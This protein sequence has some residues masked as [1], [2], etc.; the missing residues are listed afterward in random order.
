M[1]LIF[2]LLKKI[3]IIRQISFDLLK[4]KFVFAIIKNMNY[5]GK[6]AYI[7]LIS[8]LAIFFL[9]S[10]GS[11]YLYL[12]I[13]NNLGLE[14]YK[15]KIE[16]CQTGNFYY[17]SLINN[18]SQTNNS[19]TPLFSSAVEAII[20][21]TQTLCETQAL[22]MKCSG[23]TTTNAGLTVAVESSQD[24]WKFSDNEILNNLYKFQTT[25]INVGQTEAKS[26][27]F[28]NGA[29]YVKK[30]KN[31][32]KT[33]NGFSCDFNS[34]PWEEGSFYNYCFLYYTFSDKTILNADN[35]ITYKDSNGKISHYAI[36]FN[37]STNIGIQKYA[38]IVKKNSGGM[39]K[40]LPQFSTI[41]MRM[42][43]DRLGNI[44]NLSVYEKCTLNVGI[45]A[46]IVNQF[47]Y[48]FKTIE[49]APSIQ[50]PTLN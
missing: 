18:N 1:L 24:V 5:K 2:Y 20:H 25:G 28:L 10:C 7:T 23:T 14:K 12:N 30:S 27:Y 6:K 39:A 22:Y 48:E 37:L 17:K 19:E 43:I 42:Q 45:T 8:I 34:L 44:Q 3:Y 50:K 35:L 15:L 40:D 31:I 4:I 13:Y 32:N 41:K 29:A 38:D 33:S 9:I 49:N 47:L 46:E 36:E 21:A 11:C 16:N 26:T